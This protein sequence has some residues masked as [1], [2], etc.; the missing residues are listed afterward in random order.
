MTEAGTRQ[1]KDT[2]KK[3]KKKTNGAAVVQVEGVVA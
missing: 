2:F 1:K 3:Q